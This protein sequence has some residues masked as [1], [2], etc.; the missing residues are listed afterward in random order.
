[1]SDIALTSLDVQSLSEIK[2]YLIVSL[3]LPRARYL[4]ERSFDTRPTGAIA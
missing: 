2:T 4:E 3:L 1:M